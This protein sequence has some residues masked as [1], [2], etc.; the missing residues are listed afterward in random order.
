VIIVAMTAVGLNTTFNPVIRS[1][2]QVSMAEDG[3]CRDIYAY[4]EHIVCPTIQDFESN[5]RSVR[6]AFLAC[7]V[8]F[9]IVDHLA[10]ATGK[11]RRSLRQQFRGECQAFEVIDRVAHALKHAEGGHSNSRDNPPLK[12]RALYERPP[13]IW[14]NATWGRFRWNDV[15]GGVD[16]GEPHGD[17]LPIVKEAT[18]F[19]RAKLSAA[20]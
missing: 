8:V 5:P 18:A 2:R 16:T 17:L 20:G 19:I 9:H 14:G 15:T 11:K 6:H 4:F 1:G 13:A 12:A 7:L 3:L 10:A